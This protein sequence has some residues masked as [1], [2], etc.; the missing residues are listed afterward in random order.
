MF[1]LLFLGTSASAPTIERGLSSAVVLHREY[2]FMIDCGEG[3][4]RQLLRSGLG[5]KRMDRILLTHGHLDHI[6]G[7]GGLISTFGR[8]EMIPDIDIYAGRWALQRVA[9]LMAVVFG[10]VDALPMK[11]NLQEITPGVLLAD[12]EFELSAFP[13]SHRG[14]GCYGFAFM[15]KEKRPFLVD[16]AEALGV[17]AGPIRR[18]LVQGRPVTLDDGRVI[19]PDEVL[20][21]TMPGAKLVFVGDVGRTDDLIEAAAGANTLVIEATYLDEEADMARRFGHLTA[22]RAA[23]LAR[24]AGVGTLI[25]NH[26]SRRYAVRQVLA[27]A[28]P[29][30][31]NTHVASDFDRFR[32]VKQEPAEHLVDE[33]QSRRR[34][35]PEH[36]AQA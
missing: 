27:E 25:L 11:V 13:V 23:R 7:L 28:R 34:P 36:R 19:H 12:D 22:S 20:G 2:R 14:Q 18:E 26:L 29:I 21:S 6:L 9:D 35:R 5:F 33:S 4:Q 3:T 10:T 17:P 15:E 32:I 16:K 31:E 24:D 1:E 8:W 30:F